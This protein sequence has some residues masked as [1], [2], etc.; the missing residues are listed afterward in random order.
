MEL[1][2]RDRKR[3]RNLGTWIVREMPGEMERTQEAKDGREGMPCDRVWTN[4][5]CL[6]YKS[7]LGTSLSYRPSFHNY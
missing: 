4:R 1:L 3:R 7:W 5:N 6:S 2:G